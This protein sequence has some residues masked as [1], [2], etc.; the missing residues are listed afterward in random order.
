[1]RHQR[2]RIAEYHHSPTTPFVLE[3]YRVNGKRK[4]LFFRTRS[5]AELELARLKLIQRREGE[6]GAELGGERRAE[7]V[8]CIE[9]LSRFGKTLTDAT[10]YLLA[11]RNASVT[12]TRSGRKT[13]EIER[14]LF[15][16]LALF[17]HER[18]A[19]SEDCFHHALRRAGE[20]N[21]T[22]P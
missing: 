6:A 7:A 5:E 2:L 3:G 17:T 19:A 20:K 1:M 16:S 21:R 14:R 18:S 10:D 13:S 11:Q 8:R 12:A 4:R 15:L 9:R 22:D